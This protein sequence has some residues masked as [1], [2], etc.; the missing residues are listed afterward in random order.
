MHP[1]GKN[2]SG[3]RIVLERGVVKG[4]VAWCVWWECRGGGGE[5]VKTYRGFA[6]TREGAE[7]IARKEAA[8]R[9]VEGD[10]E[11]EKEKVVR[12]RG[13]SGEVSVG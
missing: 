6:W 2:S 3:V 1:R 4:K 9:G 10:V 7:Y 13:V 8:G 11:R 5:V 12:K